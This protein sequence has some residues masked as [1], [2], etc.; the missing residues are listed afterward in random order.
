MMMP[1]SLNSRVHQSHKK[2]LPHF[3]TCLLNLHVE[4]YI[5][6]Y[7][8]LPFS[9]LLFVL[10]IVH[11]NNVFSIE[12]PKNRE[13]TMNAGPAFQRWSYASKNEYEKVLLSV[14]NLY[15]VLP[16]GPEKIA[17]QRLRGSFCI[18][19]KQLTIT[20]IALKVCSFLLLSKEK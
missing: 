6:V 1:C 16:T 20:I 5:F 3:V 17:P 15:A 10:P 13:L 18:L 8:E 11:I 14:S 9:D 2:H 7:R 4:C 12:S 19:L